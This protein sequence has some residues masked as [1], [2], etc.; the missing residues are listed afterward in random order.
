MRCHS[1]DS[2]LE[3]WIGLS[4]VPEGQQHW[5]NCCV[6][7]DVYPMIME[8]AISLVLSKLCASRV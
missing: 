1:T 8:N 2:P 4:V 6:I 3:L 5:E 7:D